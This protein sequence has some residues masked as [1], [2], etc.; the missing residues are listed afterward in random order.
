MIHS[1]DPQPLSDLCRNLHPLT[2]TTEPES[3]SLS[4]P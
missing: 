2:D 3:R 4:L 1:I